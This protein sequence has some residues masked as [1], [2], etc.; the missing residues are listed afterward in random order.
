MS[1]LLVNKSAFVGGSAGNIAE[2]YEFGIKL[3]DGAFGTVLKAK[4]RATGVYRAVKIIPKAKVRNSQRLEAEINLMKATDHPHIIK[5]YEVFYD[6]INIYLVLELCTGGELFDFIV[7]K[8]HLNEEEARLITVQLL[9]AVSYLHMHDICHRDLKPENLLFVEPNA[10]NSLKLIDFGMSKMM[11]N[12]GE[13]M[14]TKVGT[15]YYIA[16]EVLTGTYNMMCDMWSIG[17]IIYALLCGYPPF[18]GKSDTIILAKVKRGSFNY[19]GAEWNSVSAEAKDLISHLLVVQPDGRL[20]AEQALSHPWVATTQPE[21]PLSLDLESL[22]RFKSAR[23]LQRSVLLCIASL[24]S[25]GEIADL[26]AKF[27]RLDVNGDGMLTF[28]ELQQGLSGTSAAELQELWQSIDVDQ[29]GSID[30]SE[31]LAAT[32]DRSIFLQEEKLWAAFSTFDKDGSGKISA[33]EL[34]AVL[35]Q[36]AV[37]EPAPGFW[38]ELVREADKNGDGEIDFSE[39]IDLVDDRKLGRAMSRLGSGVREE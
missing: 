10:I 33:E 8:R 18:D 7:S 3:G 21:V 35:G 38:E 23:K 4:H 27:E 32:M 19:N 9:R 26:K 22:A 25:E 30:Y 16:P 37:E 6:K 20:T 11:G 12:R 5:L 1:S 24:C 2:S 39:F 31:F 15:P 36:G 17:V 14:T 29:S 13:A 34:K 28:A